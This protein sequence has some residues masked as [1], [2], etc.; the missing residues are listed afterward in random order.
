MNSVALFKDIPNNNV[1]TIE[2]SREGNLIIALFML[3]IQSMHCYVSF[4]SRSGVL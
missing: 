2:N 4:G 1:I 3:K